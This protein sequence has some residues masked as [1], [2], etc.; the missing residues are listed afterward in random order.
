MFNKKI[1]NFIKYC[2]SYQRRFFLIFL[3]LLTINIS[4]I[5]LGQI[6]NNSSLIEI[7][8]QLI[9]DEDYR[10]FIPLITSLITVL[11]FMITGIYNGLIRYIASRSLYLLTLRTFIATFI[12]F[13]IFNN[14]LA[15]NISL[16][17]IFLYFIFSTLLLAFIRIFIRDIYFSA[18]FNFNNKR[19]KVLIYGTGD[20]SIQ[21]FNYLKYNPKFCVVGFID[22]NNNFRNRSISGLRI[23]SIE[24]F[25]KNYSKLNV[26]SIFITQSNVK[27]TSSKEIYA[28]FKDFSLSILKAPN[29]D[30]YTNYDEEIEKSKKIEIE[31][32]LGRDEVYP[33]TEIIEKAI[34]SKIILV[35]GGGGSIGGELCRQILEYSPKK[36]IIL[37]RNEYS[38]Y[39]LS[40]EFMQ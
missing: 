2:P 21:L 6:N 29:F 40:Q 8:N 24:S 9:I 30:K 34:K 33:K 31:D 36:L 25:K 13:S 28:L 14:F 11:T 32:L 37:E 1:V 35:T 39:Q 3:D 17:F 27:G 4:F 18:S 7:V 26:K 16:D 19:N 20:E 22:N 23:F 12:S 38:L 10:L 5:S 15:A